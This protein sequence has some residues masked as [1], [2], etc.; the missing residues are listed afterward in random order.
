MLDLEKNYLSTVGLGE[1]KENSLS[2]TKKPGVHSE[3]NRE[4]NK[5][6]YIDP[7]SISRE[8]YEDLYNYYDNKILPNGNKILCRRIIERSRGNE[9]WWELII[10]IQKDKQ[11]IA[12]VGL[13][14]DYIGPSVYWA[15]EAEVK[16]EDIED[17]L[18]VT[19]TF[20]GHIVWPRWIGVPK[21]GELKCIDKFISINQS[22]GG[23]KGFY[24]RMDLFLFDLKEW[25]LEQKCKLQSAYDKNKIWLEQFVD[26]IGFIDFFNLNDYVFSS[27][28]TVKNHCSF[29]EGKLF[30]QLSS[31]DVYPSTIPN[32]DILY[33]KFSDANVCLINKRN[34]R[35]K[36][37][38]S[39]IN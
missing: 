25:Y 38:G 28:Y 6:E 10:D 9:T 1:F 27:D 37:S 3:W 11:T 17:F 30:S 14:A 8:L 20:G 15:C 34:S 39:N 24:D 19:R 36:N 5:H 7:D 21:D 16:V 31:N 29:S 26:F 35:F 18:K 32:N 4:I 22:R 12:K 23:E 2:I 13:G 33:T